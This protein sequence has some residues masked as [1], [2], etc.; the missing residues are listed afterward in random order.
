MN[1]ILS[2]NSGK[3]FSQVIA[4]CASR[5]DTRAVIAVS[6]MVCLSTLLCVGCVVFSEYEMTL[7]SS[8]LSIKKTVDD[9]SN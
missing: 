3:S 4:E 8:G 9:E 1:D 7:S 5:L 6:G 2:V